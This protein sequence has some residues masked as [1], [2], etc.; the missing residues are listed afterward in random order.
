ML[1]TSDL[2]QA[3]HTTKA[4]DVTPRCRLWPCAFLNVHMQLI[5]RVPVSNSYFA[6]EVQRRSFWLTGLFMNLRVIS[7][8]SGGRV[9]ENTPTCS[10]IMV[11]GKKTGLT[12]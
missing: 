8:A 4:N 7:S 5:H 11:V 3:C 1:Y 12:L 9:A 6:V 10:N 2:H